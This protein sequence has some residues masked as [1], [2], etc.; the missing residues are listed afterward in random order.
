MIDGNF[1]SPNI[2]F[3]LSNIDRMLSSDFDFSLFFGWNSATRSVCA[4]L[5]AHD[6]PQAY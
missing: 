4:A 3:K 1:F 2:H 6:V 5:L